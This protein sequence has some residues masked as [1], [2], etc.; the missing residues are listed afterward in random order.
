MAVKKKN[1]ILVLAMTAVVTIFIA[2]GAYAGLN[3]YEEVYKDV[4]MYFSSADTNEVFYNQATRT[5]IN[6]EVEEKSENKTEK[7]P[8]RV[9]KEEFDS[10]NHAYVSQYFLDFLDE[11]DQKVYHQ[12][13][14]GI[15]DFEKS[16]PIENNVLKQ[17]DVGDFIVLFTS[18][19]PYV[20][21]IGAN[22]TIS[23]NKKGYVTAVNVEYSLT[24]DEAES[25]R[26]ELDRKID[27]IISGITPG[28]SDYDKVKYLHDYVVTHCNYDDKCPQPYSAYGCLVQGRCVCEGYTKAMLALCDK[29]GIKAIPVVG[30]AAETGDY[31]GHIWNKIS[32]SD[33]WYNFDVTWDDPTGEMGEKYIRYDYFGLTDKQMERNHTPDNNKYMSYPSAESSQAN[34]FEINGLVCDDGRQAGETMEKAIMQAIESK[35]GLARIRCTD[36]DAYTHALETL[37]ET[38]NGTTGTFTVLNYLLESR[39]KKKVVS[40]SIINND[41]AYTI[42][43]KFDVVAQQDEKI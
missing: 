19:N 26:R 7:T 42:T 36:K 43:V 11:G 25:Q 37:F 20:N 21:Y 16:I 22:Y 30:K 31:Q 12:L 8:P 35:E 3:R 4:K 17:D 29:A 27:S 15:Y 10:I 14:K 18:S 9:T 40:Y 28:M 32:I 5:T 24:K 39:N 38:E 13:Y 33:K 34:Y 6:Y 2:G 41:E 23:L 1:R